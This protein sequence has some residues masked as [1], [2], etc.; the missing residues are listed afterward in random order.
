MYV[1]AVLPPNFNPFTTGVADEPGSDRRAT[2]R[3]PRPSARTKRAALV[4]VELVS[5][6]AAPLGLAAFLLAG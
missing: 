2:L 6:L 3:V 4:T 1:Q 5:W